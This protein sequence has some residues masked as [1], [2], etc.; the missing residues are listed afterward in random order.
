MIYGNEME[1]RL[2]VPRE[3]EG[4]TI[5]ITALQMMLLAACCVTQM[6]ASVYAQDASTEAQQG[7]SGRGSIPEEVLRPSREESPRYP[8]DIVIG[9]LGHGEEPLRAYETARRAADAFLAGRADA[10]ALSTLSRVVVESNMSVLNEI[11]PQVVRLGGG[12]E[13]PDGSVSFM[14]RFAG[15][16]SSIAGE[17]FVRQEGRRSVE[18][19]PQS[20]TAETEVSTEEGGSAPET[21][22]QEVPAVRPAAVVEGA[23]FF[24]DIHLEEARSREVEDQESRSRFDFSPYERFF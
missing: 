2:A 3:K 10:P 4:R 17:M 1:E 8:I 7:Y 12:R 18:Q 22:E 14:V 16:D 13:E 19:A 9:P 21:Q 24:E 20:E 15:R 5:K 11:S 6:S 23:W